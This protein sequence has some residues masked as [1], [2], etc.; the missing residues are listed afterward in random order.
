TLQRDQNDDLI[1][2]ETL[3]EQLR[4]EHGDQDGKLRRL[5]IAVLSNDVEEIMQAAYVAYDGRTCLARCEDGKT[6]TRFVKDGKFL[7]K[8]IEEP[9]R[10]DYLDLKNSKGGKIWKMHTKFACVIA[11]RE[12]NWGGVY[13][14]RTTSQ[15]T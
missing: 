13:F 7:P 2:D 12:A 5:P 3:M 6:I 15:I 11:S 8:P 4:E 1:P 14:L 9:W 10:E